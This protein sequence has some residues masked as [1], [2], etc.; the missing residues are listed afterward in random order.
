MGE[1]KGELNGGTAEVYTH[2]KD[3][4][5]KIVKNHGRTRSNGFK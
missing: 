4:R 1:D 3:G 2:K 5:G